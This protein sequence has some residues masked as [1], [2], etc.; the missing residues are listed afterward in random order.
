MSR[1]ASSLGPLPHPSLPKRQ[2]LF[3]F[4]LL[5]RAMAPASHANSISPSLLEALVSG[6]WSR[7]ITRE[8]TSNDR[9]DCAGVVA[10]VVHRIFL[11]CSISV[12]LVQKRKLTKHPD[13]EANFMHS[14]VYGRR[15]PPAWIS[16]L[17]A[18]T[19]FCKVQLLDFSLYRFNS[20]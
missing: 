9:S 17:E 18:A 19:H 13:N 6:S 8:R 12:S 10:L 16:N 14:C 20:T 7:T 3:S 5:W 4:W 11:V 1:V 2:P 15:E